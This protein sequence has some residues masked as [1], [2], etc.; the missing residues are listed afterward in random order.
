[1]CVILISG[2]GG[3]LGN[4]PVKGNFTTGLN[5]DACHKIPEEDPS[6]IAVKKLNLLYHN[7]DMYYMIWFLD[8]GNLV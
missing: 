6:Q 1:M 8:Y 3:Y 5:A 4:K 2:S 7:M